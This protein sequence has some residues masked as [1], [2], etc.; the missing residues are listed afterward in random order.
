MQKKDRERKGA[1]E[2]EEQGSKTFI[3]KDEFGV[4]KYWL[5][6]HYD[7]TTFIEAIKRVK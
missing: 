1:G 2:A 7:G 5:G 3:V 4:W 6:Y